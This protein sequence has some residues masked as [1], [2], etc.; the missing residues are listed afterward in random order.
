M[1]QRMKKRGCQAAV[2]LCCLALFVNYG[3]SGAKVF[4]LVGT[5]I[6]VVG[7]L[8]ERRHSEESRDEAL[9]EEKQQDRSLQ[10]SFRMITDIVNS[11][12]DIA[13]T[14]VDEAIAQGRYDVL[15]AA[16]E[17][18]QRKEVM[19]E[20]EERFHELA[21]QMELNQDEEMAYHQI[22]YQDNVFQEGIMK[23]VGYVVDDID[24][25][26][27][28]DMIVLLQDTTGI[29]WNGIY[30]A[31]CIYF[32]MNEDEPYC[33]QDEDFPFGYSLYLSSEDLDNDGNMEIVFESCG[34]GYGGVGD[35]YCRILKYKDH[36]MT[37][38][39]LPSDYADGTE[40][41]VKVTQELQRDTYS[42]YCPYLDEMIIFQAANA[43]EPYGGG[44]ANCRGFYDLECIEYKG[45]PALEASE[46]LYGEGGIAHAVGI[47]K[48]IIVWDEDGNSRIDKW[49]VE[50]WEE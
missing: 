6:K 29:E 39:K 1:I 4:P 12:W 10:E 18:K 15:L 26:G 16:R 11:E 38:M 24:R 31:G 25:N 50:P 3:K 42:A 23:L 2:L 14:A 41:D 46:Y 45:G 20:N 28:G 27:Q 17:E 32:Y 19:Q 13:K 35:W 30:G 37:E 34:T 49:W 36:T 40:I 33:F 8:G 9:Q 44:G 22:L 43:F 47:A 7:L 5:G 21:D 48:F